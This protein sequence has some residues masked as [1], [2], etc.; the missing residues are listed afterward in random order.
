MLIS[1]NLLS[2]NTMKTLQ[3]S[4]LTSS[5]QWWDK[6]AKL[7]GRRRARGRWLQGYELLDHVAHWQWNVGLVLENILANTWTNLEHF[8]EIPCAFFTSLSIYIVC[9]LMKHLLSGSISSVL[10]HWIWSQDIY[11]YGTGLL[12][13]AGQAPA[14]L[15]PSFSPSKRK[16]SDF[17]MYRYELLLSVWWLLWATRNK[18]Q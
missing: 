5:I 1:A 12:G 17:A 18:K 6:T 14:F 3:I 13:S 7:A 15:C 10:C 11:L 2:G 4:G 16:D 9:K 8:C